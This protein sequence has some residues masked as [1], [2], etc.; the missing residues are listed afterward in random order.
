[1]RKIEL[2]IVYKPYPEE[3]E[4]F[5]LAVSKLTG[6]TPSEEKLFGFAGPN[7]VV[8]IIL[9]AASWAL[10]LKGTVA[11]LGGKFLSSYISELGKHAA[12]K[13]IEAFQAKE[14]NSESNI[15]ADS[16]MELVVAIKKLREK[17]QTVTIAVKLPDT[18]RNAGFIIETDDPRE[19]AKQI[20]FIAIHTEEIQNSYQAIINKGG[21]V[22]RTGNNP[23][24]SLKIELLENGD[25]T[26]LGEKLELDKG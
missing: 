16:F 10:V 17:G 21:K 24:M 18:P 8:Q 15:D 13:T 1:M 3:L 23:D 7:D 22:P 4:E 26:F 5:T 12:L 19:I 6:L 2:G 11:F 9:D 20:S 14:S 25:V